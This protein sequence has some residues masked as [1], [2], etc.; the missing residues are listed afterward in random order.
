MET[1]KAR[2]AVRSATGH[3][4]KAGTGKSYCGHDL[5][6]TPTEAQFLQAICKTC[7]KAEKR[8]RVKAEQVAAASPLAAAAVG[9]AEAVEQTDAMQAKTHLDRVE[10][11]EGE[12]FTR[13]ARAV[14][15]VE[16]AEISKATDEALPRLKA[17]AAECADM[18]NRMRTQP[19]A[20]PIVVR[21]RPARAALDRI[22]ANAAAA[23]AAH[24]AEMD[25]HR[26][27]ETAEHGTA[28]SAPRP[29]YPSDKHGLR[30]RHDRPQPAEQAVERRAVEG[31]IVAHNGRTKGAAPKHSGHPDAIAAIAALGDLKLAEVTDR[32]DVGAVPGG[33]DHD[34]EVRGALVVPRGEGRVAVY[35]TEAGQWITPSRDPWAVE[36][37]II[38]DKLR[39]AG[40]LI[41]PNSRRC[42]FARRRTQ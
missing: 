42:V 30:D 28:A 23:R 10:T 18:I 34:P 13:A 2:R 29:Q 35:W 38:A 15:A 32:T 1:Y 4:R 5:A 20:E 11:E 37:Q 27:A 16:A 9:V 8:N 31:V 41:E 14:D 7:V 17:S 26:A 36:L 33:V 40:W 39:K 3:Y 19:G 22:K 24:R 6:H 12:K 21:M 25:D